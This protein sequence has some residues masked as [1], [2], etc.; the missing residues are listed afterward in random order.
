MEIN[1]TS[2]ME[3]ENGKDIVNVKVTK[4]RLEQD[5]QNSRRKW[6]QF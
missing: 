6:T 5:S 3:V 4:K 1:L 2:I